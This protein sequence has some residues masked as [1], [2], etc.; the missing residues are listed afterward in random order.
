M[1]MG[2]QRRYSMTSAVA[3][4]CSQ[5]KLI[6]R[7]LFQQGKG[8]WKI[9]RKGLCKPCLFNTA[10]FIDVCMF[11]TLVSFSQILI[12]INNI[13]QRTLTLTTCKVLYHLISIFTQ[14][15]WIR[16]AFFFPVLFYRCRKF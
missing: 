5:V 14:I 9:S 11:F 15:R 1:Q 3:A 2:G 4:N 7:G 6:R 12:P 13:W 8:L 10:G 16:W